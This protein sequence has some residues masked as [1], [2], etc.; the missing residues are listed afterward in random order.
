MFSLFPTARIA[1]AAVVGL[2]YCNPPG[3]RI[4]T[5]ICKI[6]SYIL[7]PLIALLM[8]LGLLIFLWG[9]IQFL[10]NQRTGE[11][12]KI[13]DGKRHMIWG[14]IGLLVM[15]SVY[16]IMGLIA[17]TFNLKNTQ[18]QKIENQIPKSQNFG[19]FVH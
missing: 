19:T 11:E 3:S 14:V 17:R 1:H 15:V 2:S 10:L 12:A 13:A 7:D 4:D 6:G 9:M 8:T 18:N 16:G 5:I